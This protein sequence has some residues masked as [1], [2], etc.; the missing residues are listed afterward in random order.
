MS[1][2]SVILYKVYEGIREYGRYRDDTEERVKLMHRIKAKGLD[3]NTSDEAIL[4]E[5]LK[6]RI[7]G[8]KLHSMSAAGLNSLI[9]EDVNDAMIDGYFN[10]MKRLLKLDKFRKYTDKIPDKVGTVASTLFMTKT[11]K[12]YQYARHTVQMTD[13]LG[14]YVMMEYAQNVQKKSFKVAM[15]EALDAF[16]LFD[17]ALIPALEMIDAVGAT[18]FISYYL[19]NAR[20]SK[21][22]VQT[23]PTSVGLSAIAQHS[24]GLSTLGNVNSSWIGGKFSPNTLQFDD[25]FDEAN[26]M[27]LVD[28]VAGAIRDIIN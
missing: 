7:E 6:H 17:E 10:R 18:S 27:T 23:S 15:H 20:A 24:T 28:I 12:P 9:V 4:V 19:R 5:R 1:R 13:F 11:S 21:Q 25:L 16:V 22:L 8:N 2:N 3:E 26:N 14:R